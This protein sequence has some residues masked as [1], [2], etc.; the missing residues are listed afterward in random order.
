MYKLM[1]KTHNKTGLKYLC[2]TRQKNYLKYNGSGKYWLDHINKHGNNIT[3]TILLETNDHEELKKL[4]QY[5]SNLWNIVESNDWA[6]LR[7]EEGTGGNTVSNKFWITDGTTDKYID[8]NIPIPIGWIRGRTTGGFKNKDIQKEL[9][10]RAH[11]SE[12]YKSAMKT[13]G[14]K[15]SLAKKGK[16]NYSIRGDLNPSKKLEVRKKISNSAKS[17]PFITCNVCG[18]VGQQSPGMFRFHFE[19]CRI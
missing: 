7:P 12:N 11:D 5:Y 10:K 19:K 6:N 2:Q 18:K 3:T 8:K 4:G 9:S 16:P 14:K 17:R 15:I 13:V 1:I